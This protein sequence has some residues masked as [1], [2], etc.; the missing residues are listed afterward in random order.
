[1]GLSHHACT[2]TYCTFKT[3]LFSFG[4]LLWEI[5]SGELPQR[6]R[7]RALRSGPL[8]RLHIWHQHQGPSIWAAA[9]AAAALH[10]LDRQR[11]TSPYSGC[12]RICCFAMEA[13]V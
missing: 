3:D 1:M 12:G 11:V 4:V 13:R 7:Y 2:G 8:L 9:V 5:A 6:G 10:E